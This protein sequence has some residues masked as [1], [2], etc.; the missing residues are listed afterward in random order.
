MDDKYL[1]PDMKNKLKAFDD[2]KKKIKKFSH[3]E[4]TEF[5]KSVGVLN[6]KGKFRSIE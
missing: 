2:Y 4:A 3:A 5:L 1:S 6:Q